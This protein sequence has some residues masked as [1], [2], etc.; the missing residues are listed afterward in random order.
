MYEISANFDWYFKHFK[1]FGMFYQLFM[2]HMNCNSF[3][4][5][6]FLDTIRYQDHILLLLSAFQ[7]HKS[8]QL[9][10]LSAILM[11]TRSMVIGQA[12][13]DMQI[14]CPAFILPILI[15]NILKN[16]K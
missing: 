10:V 7:Q 9:N 11:V 13:Y 6:I 3:V 4:F 12:K 14:T 1:S 2:E 16:L 5:Q 15:G 8:G